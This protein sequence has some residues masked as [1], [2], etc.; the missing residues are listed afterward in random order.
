MPD[1]SHHKWMSLRDIGIQC[2][3]KSKLHTSA[4]FIYYDQRVLSGRLRNNQQHL[5]EI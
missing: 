5:R 2:T 3:V 4:E 1:Q